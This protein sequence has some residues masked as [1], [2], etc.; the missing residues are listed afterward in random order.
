MKILIVITIYLLMPLTCLLL[1][2]KLRRRFKIE[3]LTNAPTAE[4]FVVFITY[5]GLLLLTLTSLI[6]PLDWSG[7]AS[8]GTFYLVFVAPILMGIIAFRLRKARNFSKYHKWTYNSGLLYYVIAPVIMF[9]LIMI[10]VK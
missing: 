2:L 8:L 6:W 4:L 3:N 5:G 1:Y 10:T 7:I 9:S